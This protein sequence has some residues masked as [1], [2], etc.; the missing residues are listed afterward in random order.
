MAKQVKKRKPT[1]LE[2]EHQKLGGHIEALAK[3]I[4][5]EA[6]SWKVDL[7]T[8]PGENL[9]EFHERFILARTYSYR[10]TALLGQVQKLRHGVGRIVAALRKQYGDRV[11]ELFKQDE[12][13]KAKSDQLRKRMVEAEAASEKGMLELYEPLE[14]TLER[15][16]WFCHHCHKELGEVRMDLGSQLTVI[17][18]QIVTG[19]LKTAIPLRTVENVLSSARRGDAISSTAPMGGK[20]KAKKKRPRKGRRRSSPSPR[21]Q[22]L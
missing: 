22:P 4:F 14:E 2:I 18:H 12:I 10:V 16:Y 9:G 7:V 6:P 1:L 3:T 11:R 8:N 17:R 21:I 15:L 5:G 13:R 19:E 20:P